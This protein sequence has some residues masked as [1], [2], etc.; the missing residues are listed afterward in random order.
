M[1]NITNRTIKFR[2]LINEKMVYFSLRNL[3]EWGDTIR[4]DDDKLME[5]TGATDKNEKEIYEDDIVIVPA[6]YEGD[7]YY[8]EAIAEVYWD[9]K[10]AGFCIDGEKCGYISLFDFVNNWKGTVI[11]NIWENPEL[12]K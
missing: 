7:R 1:N 8:E 5:F 3:Q 10:D 11:G 6:H 2:A 9:E 4:W 12:L